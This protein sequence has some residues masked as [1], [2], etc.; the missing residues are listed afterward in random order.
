MAHNNF[1]QWLFDINQQRGSKHAV[2]DQDHALTYQEL[3]THSRIFAKHLTRSS[4]TSGQRVIICMDDCVAWPVAFLGCILVGA[5]PVL[6]SPDLYIKSLEQ[7]VSTCDAKAIVCDDIVPDLGIT[8]ISRDDILAPGD[9]LTV[10]YQF[11]DDEPC[12]WLLT[13]GTSGDSKCIMHRHAA[14][15]HLLN[16]VSDLAF[17]IRE[18]S[19][20]FCTGKLSWA[21]GLNNSLT[22][23]L[24]RGATAYLRKGAPAP[25]RIYEICQQHHIT[26][27]LTVPTVLNSMIRYPGHL[28]DSVRIVT[29]S[30]EPL[31]DIVAKRF[32]ETFQRQVYV[33][34]GQSEAMQTYAAV[35]IDDYEFGSVGKPLPGIECELRDHRGHRVGQGRIGEMYV[36][37][38]CMALGYYKDWE[39]TRHTFQGAWI[40]TGDI[41]KQLPSGGYRFIGRA[42]DLIKIRGLWVSPMEVENAIMHDPR[43]DDCAVIA[44][45]NSAGLD[46]I[47]AYVVASKE[48]PD[49]KTQVAEQLVSFKV[50][51]H[52]HWV[53][54]LP[55]TV[56]RKR[57]RAVLRGQNPVDQ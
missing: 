55:R 20:V 22:F 51:R 11:H 34:I 9:E 6:T 47:H 2:V 53:K 8:R 37:T 39:S 23:P 43:V 49:L 38:P 13:S 27:L 52:W 35:N 44:K 54:D 36:K 42:N 24:G 19:R 57:R 48:I 7:I 31:P 12:L 29:S 21:Y 33:N 56:T 15:Q 4:I 10:P 32:Y 14:F 45:P 5:N 40:R 30:G 46:E 18:D 50:P 28:D 17:D 1:A 26:H 25:R 41:M 3:A 16:T